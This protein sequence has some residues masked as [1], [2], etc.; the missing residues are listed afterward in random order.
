MSVRLFHFSDRPDIAVFEPR[1]VR[2]PAERRPRQEWLNGPL[3]W[4]ID[5]WHEPLYL[6]PRECPRILLWPTERTTAEDHA[7]WFG[8][9]AAR[10][11]AFVEK[12]RADSLT[13]EAV[14]R[15]EMPATSFEDIGDAGMWVSRAPVTP[16][17]MDALTDLPKELAARDVELRLCESFLPLKTLWQTTLHASGLRLRNVEDWGNPGWPHSQPVV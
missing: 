13:T 6:F 15:Y 17:R 9:S 5:V 3:V 1:P 12:S 4:A 14:Y 11:I 2:V 16:S 10:M 7:R 8:K